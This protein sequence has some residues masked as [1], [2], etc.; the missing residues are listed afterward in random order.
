MVDIADRHHLIWLRSILIA[1]LSGSLILAKECGCFIYVD[2]GKETVECL[3]KN[4]AF[5]LFNCISFA[6][7]PP[8][9]HEP[10]S[11]VIQAES[12]RGV[13]QIG[14]GKM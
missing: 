4:E 6:F 9:H 1:T 11:T 10:V 14:Q 5:F 8:R 7:N 12:L 13:F 3:C 2:L